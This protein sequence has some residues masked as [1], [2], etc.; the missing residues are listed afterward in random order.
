MQQRV[1]R[2]VSEGVVDDLEAVHIDE[3]DG[4]PA[5]VALRPR[6]GKFQTVVKHDAVGQLG[7]RV[8][9]GHEL[10]ALLG[11]LAHRVL[12]DLAADG[13][14]GSNER[15]IGLAHVAVEEFQHCEHL[16]A[17]QQ[18]E[19]EG[20]VQIGFGHQR[21]AP[22]TLGPR[23]VGDPYRLAGA[24]GASHQAFI[25]SERGLQRA[26]R[27]LNHEFLDFGAVDPPELVTPQHAGIL[28]PCPA[29]A[30]MPVQR[31]ANG[32][33]DRG[34]GLGQCF[35]SGQHARD[36]VLHCPALLGLLAFGYVYDGTDQSGD[37]AA[38]AR[39]GGF[40]V[41]G[42]VGRAVGRRD[43]GFVGL[44]SGTFPQHLVVG[45]EPVGRIFV[46]RVEVVNGL[47]DERVPGYPEVPFPRLVDAEITPVGA[48]E[49]DRGGQRLDQLLG[50][51][52]RLGVLARGRECTDQAGE[53]HADDDACQQH[54][55]RQQTIGGV[56]EV[57]LRRGELQLPQAPADLELHQLLE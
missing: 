41:D 8:V 11:L 19:A 12:A 1:S 56:E 48:F 24:V 37:P 22:E 10:Q 14:R 16:I 7:E 55:P 28:V 50:N 13:M 4:K 53:E 33:N 52:P 32:L 54:D 25:A 46:V 3:H 35:R 18:R 21:G 39:V 51:A 29:R 30:A 42:I 47:A 6:H 27:V 23:Q 20:A 44:R 49:I 40:V 26:L 2:F 38:G 43:G 57:M 34:N 31:L 36:R 5:P 15:V 9:L 45:M 17:E